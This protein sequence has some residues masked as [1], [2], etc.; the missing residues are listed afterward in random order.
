M[1]EEKKYWRSKVEIICADAL[2]ALQNKVNEFAADKFVVG[3]Q[4]PDAWQFGHVVAVVS[5]KVLEE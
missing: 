3:I 2:P 4:Y 1:E 5:Y